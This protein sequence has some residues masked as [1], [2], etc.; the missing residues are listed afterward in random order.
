MSAE[1]PATP[2]EGSPSDGLL[3]AL[4]ALLTDL[5]AAGVVELDVAVGEARL[6]VRQ[7]PGTVPLV[8]AVPAAAAETSAEIE[9]EG[10]IAV[11]SPLS[12][13]FYTAPGPDEPPYVTEGDEVES[14]QVVGLVEAM[15]VFNEIRVEV[16]GTVAKILA[17]TGQTVQ[18]GQS[19]M[20][21]RPHAA[22]V[23]GEAV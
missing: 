17:G 4:P 3:D 20:R 7:H 11:S 21:V 15:K 13:I 1:P 8:A 18:A 5:A 2:A 16:A 9:E 22:P 19:L 12:G 14:G 6:Y 23:G 10:L